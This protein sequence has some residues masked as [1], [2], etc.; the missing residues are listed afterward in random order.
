MFLRIGKCTYVY[1]VESVSEDGRTRQHIIR[2]LGRRE[3][4]EAFGD[5]ER[6]V[7]TENSIRVEGRNLVS[8]GGRAFAADVDAKLAAL[9]WMLWRKPRNP[10]RTIHRGRWFQRRHRDPG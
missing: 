3:D 10:E 4:V 2:N 5:L 8:R 7:P 1:L 6:L 9:T